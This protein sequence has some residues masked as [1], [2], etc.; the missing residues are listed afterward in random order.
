VQEA[1]RNGRRNR[2]L[3]YGK[4]VSAIRNE[5]QRSRHRQPRLSATGSGALEL[6]PRGDRLFAVGLDAQHP[7]ITEPGR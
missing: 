1:G 6:N 2:N 4:A 3:T 5:G 7:P